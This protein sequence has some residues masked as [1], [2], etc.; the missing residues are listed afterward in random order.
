MTRKAKPAAP[1]AAT[2]VEAMIRVDHAGEYGAVRIYEGQLAVLG[3]RKGS[4]RSAETIRHMAAQEQRHLKT[5]D[6][7]V[8][9][10]K[11]RPTALEPVWRVA[12]F[13]LGAATAL[14][15]EKAAFACTAAVEEVIDEHYASQIEALGDKDDSL[16]ATVA[17]FRA[18][19][20]AHRETA[21]AEGAEQ[22]PGYRFLSEAIK[23][24]CRVAIRLSEKI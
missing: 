4:E 23:A 5:F 1:G 15:G 16:K 21:L 24:G 19:E 8:N 22:A 6:A 20:A 10:R 2:D 12:G 9:E 7:L 11:V 14:M 18:D 13:A 17:D 3:R